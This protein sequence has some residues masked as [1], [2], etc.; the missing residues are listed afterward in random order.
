MEFVPQPGELFPVLSTD[1]KTETEPHALDTAWLRGR[2][3]AFVGRLGGTNRRR[4]R[5]IVRDAGG[6]AVD[7][8]IAA[9]D[10]VVLGADLSPTDELSAVLSDEVIERAGA[11]QVEIISE[12]EWW[13]RL[14]VVEDDAATRRLYTPAMLAELLKVPLAVVRRWHRVGLIHPVRQIHRLPY[15]D[16]AE[17]ASA[18]Q[19]AR[20]LAAGNSAAQIE[21]RFARLA[22]RFPDLARP[23]SQLPLIVE[24]R[25]ILL[26]K[27]NGLV[28][29]DGQMRLEFEVDDPAPSAQPELGDP[30][31]A[32]VAGFAGPVAESG[33]PPTPEAPEDF[34]ALANDLEDEGRLREAGEVCRAMLLAHGATAEGAFRLAE[35]LYGQGQLAAARERYSMAVELAPDYVEARASLGCVLLELQEPEQA[36]AA[37]QGALDVHPEYPDVHYHLARLLDD[38]NQPADAEPHWQAFLRLAPHSPWAG[39]ARQR[40]GLAVFAE[41]GE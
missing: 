21:S 1:V 11:G 16:F 9:C 6:T 30:A 15:F 28:E 35:L 39:E 17:V 38:R 27:G 40:L 8:S 20:L 2:A 25:Q 41:D 37:F 7:Q 13:H 31:G 32:A 4:A 33:P 34:I 36:L 12:T 23:L 10:L 3:V 18:R 5:Q 22:E 14:G 24:G 26:R 29:P 19:L